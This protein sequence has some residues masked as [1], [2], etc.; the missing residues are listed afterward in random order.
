[1]SYYRGWGDTKMLYSSEEEGYENHTFD[2]REKRYHISETL[3]EPV[4]KEYENNMQIDNIEKQ[5]A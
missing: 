2:I 1:M 3:E 5:F 4:S